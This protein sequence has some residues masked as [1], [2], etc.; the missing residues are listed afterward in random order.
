MPVNVADRESPSGCRHPW[1]RRKTAPAPSRTEKP[2]RCGDSNSSRRHAPP[3]NGPTAY[4]ASR[5]RS[6]N[7]APSGAAAH[8]PVTCQAQVLEEV[9]QGANLVEGQA[10]D[11]DEKGNLQDEFDAEFTAA[12]EPGNF[13]YRLLG[14][15]WTCKR[16]APCGHFPV[17]TRGGRARGGSRWVNAF[18]KN[19]FV[20][21]RLG[22]FVRGA[23]A[24]TSTVFLLPGFL[25]SAAGLLPLFF[26]AQGKRLFH[27][28]GA[29]RR[30]VSEYVDLFV[31]FFDS[32]VGRLQLA[33][34]G[35]RRSTRRL[36]SIRP[37]AHPV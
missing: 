5:T 34:R 12:Q 14:P 21:T 19:V 35:A 13:A 10:H 23:D 16:S 8:R 22:D 6:A 4:T 24:A 20:L 18:G 31:E 32:L 26:G 33:L 25:A 9:Q 11:I 27:L 3:P 15:R 30:F 1:A 17:A 28:A 37:H 2:T 36:A 7:A 29:V